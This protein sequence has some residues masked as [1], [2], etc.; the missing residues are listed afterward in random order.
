VV[1]DETGAENLPKTKGRAI[2]LTADGREILQTPLVT[3]EIIKKILAPHVIKKEE[4]FEKASVN[5]PPRT[6]AVVIEE[7]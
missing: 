5:Q 4:R 7:V 2:Y 3:S 1:L 6:D